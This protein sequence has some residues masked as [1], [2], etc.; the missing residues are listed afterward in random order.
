MSEDLIPS[1]AFG[2]LGR[3]RDEELRFWRLIEERQLD[4]DG[5]ERMALACGHE[6]TCVIPYPDTQ[7]YAYCP[8]CVK[9]WLE[10]ERKVET[11]Q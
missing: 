2:P 8:Q 1:S 6:T 4:D 9:K 3:P 11:A 10:A 7:E 5:S